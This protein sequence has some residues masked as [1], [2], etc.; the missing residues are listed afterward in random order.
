MQL[1]EECK[2]RMINRA[3]AMTSITGKRDSIIL[4]SFVIESGIFSGIWHVLW[5]AASEEETPCS[6]TLMPCNGVPCLCRK[7]SDSTPMFG[8]QHFIQIVEMKKEEENEEVIDTEPD[9]NADDRLWP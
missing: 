9:Y 1:T 5:K 2:S 6:I 3:A 4:D 8:P 7:A